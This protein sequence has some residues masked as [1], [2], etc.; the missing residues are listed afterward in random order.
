M[1]N[2]MRSLLI[3]AF[4]ILSSCNFTKDNTLDKYPLYREFLVD[5]EKLLELKYGQ[6]KKKDLFKMFIQEN[7][8]MYPTVICL[9]IDNKLKKYL[10]KDSLWMPL[11]QPNGDSI[12]FLNFNGWFCD[13][14]EEIKD[15]EPWIE[16]YKKTVCFD[17]H[18]GPT[19][20]ANVLDYGKNSNLKNEKMRFFIAVHF[21][22]VMLDVGCLDIYNSE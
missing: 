6:H 4:L 22:S 5:F 10:F 12:Y 9:D 7:D 15:I 11:K 18:I 17:A 19:A 2:K 1:I 16:E 14:L 13:F 3:V 21:Y 8:E 20:I